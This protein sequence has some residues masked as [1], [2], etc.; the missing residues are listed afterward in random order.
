VDR[1]C[2][3]E[4]DIAGLERRRRLALDLILQRT[5]EDVDDLFARMPVSAECCCRVEL[6]AHL[7]DLAARYA[8]IV[9]LEID[10]PDVLLLRLRHGQR[11]PACREQNRDRQDSHHAHADLEIV[12]RRWAC[13][14]RAG[15]LNGF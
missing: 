5:R 1:P 10:A 6:D 13:D 3:D 7:Y 2:R 11:Q 4:Q 12:R 15:R 9:A 8:Q 14:A